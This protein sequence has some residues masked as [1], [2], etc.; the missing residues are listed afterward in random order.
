MVVS[1]SIWGSSPRI[2]SAQS[3]RRTTPSQLPTLEEVAPLEGAGDY[4][5][6]DLAPCE[7]GK[8]VS[9]LEM[10]R[11]PAGPQQRDAPGMAHVVPGE[12]LTCVLVRLNEAKTRR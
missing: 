12:A 6:V 9:C 8:R 7:G 4:A 1:W 3:S 2:A 11:P 5:E 10:F